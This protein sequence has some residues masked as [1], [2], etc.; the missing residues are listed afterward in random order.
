MSYMFI[1]YFKYFIHRLKKSYQTELY[2]KL[3]YMDHVIQGK[4]RLAFERDFEAIFNDEKCKKNL[5]LILF[6]LDNLKKINDVHGH[7]SGDSAIKKAYEIMTEVFKDYGECYRIGGD[8]FACLYLNNDEVLYNQKIKTLE[9]LTKEINE[10]SPYRFGVSLGSAVI[11]KE[12]MNHL[13]LYE[14]ADKMM[15]EYRKLKKLDN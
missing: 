2:E 8:E 15:Y 10:K 3:A 12:Q 14:K 4:N 5:R 13:E 7:I 6:D 11:D 9:S 1:N